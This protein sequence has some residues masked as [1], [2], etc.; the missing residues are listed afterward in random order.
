MKY[1][2]QKRLGGTL[3]ETWKCYFCNKLQNTN[4]ILPVEAKDPECRQAVMACIDCYTYT[5]DKWQCSLCEEWFEEEKFDKEYLDD[6]GCVLSCEDC[7][8]A[9]ENKK[10]EDLDIYKQSISEEDK[11]KYT[12]EFNTVYPAFNK[13]L[14]KR[15]ITFKTV[16][17]FEEL[18]N[19]KDK[20]SEIHNKIEGIYDYSFIGDRIMRRDYV[21]NPE[22]IRHIFNTAPTDDTLYYTNDI[23]TS[24]TAYGKMAELYDKE[25]FDCDDDRYLVFELLVEELK[26]IDNLI[27]NQLT[28]AKKIINGKV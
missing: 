22:S 4:D 28:R 7:F 8:K 24:Y 15:I 23:I 27:T 16:S 19:L 17:Q 21:K 18:E 11:L 5:L 9:R 12:G 26:K 6:E 14:N 10:Y 2:N 13:L 1:W 25:E 20:I 3:G